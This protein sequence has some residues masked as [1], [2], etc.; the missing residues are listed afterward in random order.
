MRYIF[1]VIFLAI[2]SNS[3]AGVFGPSTYDECI[4]EN[5]KGTSSDLAARYVHHA[6]REKFPFKIPRK[7]KQ[8]DSDN[9]MQQNTAVSRFDNILLENC[10]QECKSAGYLSR[11]LGE[12]KLE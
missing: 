7:C 3:Y 5:M 12:C 9:L 6:C 10:I 11:T 8:F 4:L 2:I 1:F